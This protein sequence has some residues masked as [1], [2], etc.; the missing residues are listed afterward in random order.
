MTKEEATKKYYD[1]VE[2][3]KIEDVDCMKYNYHHI[4]PLFELKE[5][6]GVKTTKEI[7][8]TK[9]D[10]G[11]SLKC[12][13][14]HHIML[15]YYLCFMF[16]RNDKLF[17]NAKYS[18]NLILGKYKKSIDELSEDEILIIAKMIE[19]ISATN[20]TDEEKKLYY[21]N[22]KEK[23]LEKSKKYYYEHQDKVKDYRNNRKEI[24]HKYNKVYHKEKYQK[25][26]EDIKLKNSR[27]CLDP[28]F[29]NITCKSN[30]THYK[31]EKF[32]N[33]N[34]LVLWA[35]RHK[36]HIL[37]EG[38]NPYIWAEKYLIT[39]EFGNYYQFDDFDEVKDAHYCNTE[40][41]S[42]DC[43]DENKM[44]NDRKLTNNDKLCLDPR[45]NKTVEVKGR[46][47]VIWDNQFCTYNAL[48]GWCSKNKDNP[49][50]NGMSVNKF[51]CQFVLTDLDNNY[52]F[53]SKKALEL[54]NNNQ[55]I[56]GVKPCEIERKQTP[57][58]LCV[59]T[60]EVKYS[61]Q[62]KKLGYQHASD[63]AKGNRN[64]NKG[65]HFKFIKD[66]NGNYIY[67]E[68]TALKII[69][70]NIIDIINS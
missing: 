50:L 1:L 21:L 4:K 23:I 46:N 38:E 45:Y 40:I 68:E 19:D 63:V 53:D 27:V 44:S 66:E 59:E 65:L 36:T 41:K 57:I 61:Y 54:L 9:F 6:L 3:C 51:V 20:L 22:H 8:G 29:G 56:V 42:I 34:A 62:W 11:D 32:T 52:I 49:L 16:D 14:L 58:I 30:N 35:T 7:R 69:N 26:K 64:N 5:K 39:D 2:Q 28:R 43:S 67:D 24:M 18:F 10:N 17:Y 25:D 55:I 15:H 60:N 12:S 48:F 13:V 47:V 37:L 70:S 31:Y 33:Y